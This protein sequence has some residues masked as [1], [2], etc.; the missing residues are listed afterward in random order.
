M[1]F[2]KLKTLTT[3]VLRDIHVRARFC[4]TL[5]LNGVTFVNT[6]L[7]ATVSEGNYIAV[8]CNIVSK[9]L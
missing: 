6:H 5:R 1:Q 9:S 2:M 7:Q 3:R 4:H 8:L